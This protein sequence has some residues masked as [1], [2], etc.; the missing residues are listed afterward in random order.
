MYYYNQKAIMEPIAES[1]LIRC[2]TDFITD[3]EKSKRK[4]FDPITPSINPNTAEA[5]R[6]KLLESGMRNKRSV[7]EIATQPYPKAHF[8]T[9]PMEIPKICIMAGCPV[10]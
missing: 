4:N 3:N 7:W 8:A 5:T 6:Q 1:T 2:N 9:F 10:D